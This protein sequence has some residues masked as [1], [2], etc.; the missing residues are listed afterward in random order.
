MLFGW[1]L[2]GLG[3]GTF[4]MI[5]DRLPPCR[6]T[7][8]VVELWGQLIGVGLFALAVNIQNLTIIYYC[9]LIFAIITTLIA[10]SLNRKTI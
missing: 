7:S 6:G 9:A 5:K 4:Y 10:I 1:F 8:E 3:G 2:T